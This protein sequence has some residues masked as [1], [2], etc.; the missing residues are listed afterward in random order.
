[1]ELWRRLRQSLIKSAADFNT[2][3]RATVWGVRV[4]DEPTGPVIIGVAAFPAS[5]VEVFAELSARRVVCEYR[6][7]SPRRREFGIQT[8]PCTT[9]L[10]SGEPITI[11]EVVDLILMPLIPGAE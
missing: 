1:M 4:S 7:G 9:L 5:S 2:V 6:G 10:H 11:P 8:G 3:S